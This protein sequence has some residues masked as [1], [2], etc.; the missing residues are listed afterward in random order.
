MASKISE[1]E[2]Q[3]LLRTVEM[4]EA[5][6]ESQHDDYQSLEIL[7]EAYIKLSRT[8]DG[9]R[10]SKKLAQAYVSLGQIS[11]AILEYE[12]ILQEYPNDASVVAAL[13]ELEQKTSMLAAEH[14]SAAPLLAEDSKPSTPAGGPAGAPALSANRLK[15]EDGD[16][17][18]ADVLLADKFVTEQAVDPLLQRLKKMRENPED[19][20]H[21]FSLVQLLVNEQIAKL[22]DVLTFLINKSGLPYLPLSIYDVDRDVA[23]LLPL[24]VCSQFCIVP[25]DLISRSVLIATANPFNQ[26][27]LQQIE[28][29]LDYSIFWYVS[30]PTEIM[31]TLHRAHGLDGARQQQVRG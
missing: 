26:V 11:Q 25:V 14:A 1:E 7:K 9:L 16:R 12:G 31:T 24:D 13:G 19:K 10:V 3:Q 8:E 17:A 22:D 4:F 30:S 5:I 6:T 21:P 27:A 15:A 20:S 29:M 28:A 18:L 23:H 2:T